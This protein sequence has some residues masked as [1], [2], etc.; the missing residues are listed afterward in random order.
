M[1]L[2][3]ASAILL[4]FV[5]SLA[6][7]CNNV[8]RPASGHRKIKIAQ[9]GQER[10]LIYL[11]IYL[12]QS[13]GFFA[14]HSIDADLMF[15]GNDDQVFATVVRGDAQFGVGDPIFAAISTERGLPGVVV[16]SIVGKVAL[17]GVAK[18][19]AKM[20]QKPEDLANLRIGTFPRPS[21]T[22]TLLDDT[23]RQSHVRARIVEVQIGS[24]LPL[25]ESGGADMVFLLEPAASLAESQGYSI[26]TS[27]PALWGNFAFT[28]L[29]T[30]YQYASSNASLTADM[31][32]AIGEA[33]RFAHSNTPETI[34]AAQK[35][36]PNI[37][38]IG[39]KT[40][41]NRMITE[42]TLP[43]SAAVDQDGWK[44]AIKVRQEVG[45]LKASGDFLQCL[46]VPK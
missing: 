46:W 45:D 35:L 39:V 43:A 42:Q 22:Y 28:G 12:A 24:E 27:L 19:G 23:L 4:C 31:Q 5:I 26:V 30:T 44:R 41:V 16:A 34:A 3:R 9:W 37:D 6:T 29:T 17:W 1:I 38:P 32:A 10:Y 13:Q 14:K 36:F 15:S 11:P 25:L 8:S 18:K 40:A 2:K 7:G 21:T 20:I 33:V